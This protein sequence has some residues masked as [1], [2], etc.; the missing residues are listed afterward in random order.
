MGNCFLHGNRGNI[1]QNY[2]VKTYRTEELLD[3]DK[4]YENT[5]G[6]VTDVDMTGYFFQ[7]SYPGDMASYLGKVWFETTDV[8]GLN[9]TPMKNNSITIHLKILLMI[10]SQ[11][12]N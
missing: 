2:R 5:I 12:N 7:R 3:A 9:F 1:Q 6:V 8:S 11:K 10:C 4:P